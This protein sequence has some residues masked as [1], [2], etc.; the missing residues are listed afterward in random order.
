MKNQKRQ[1]LG[2]A[3]NKFAGKV[4]ALQRCEHVVGITPPQPGG[5][6]LRNISTV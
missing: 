3:V 6:W 4:Q 1:S 5:N 2:R